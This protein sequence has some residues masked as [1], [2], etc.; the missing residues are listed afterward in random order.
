MGVCHSEPRDLQI[1]IG[2]AKKTKKL[3]CSQMSPKLQSIPLEALRLV[4]LREVWLQ[5]NEISE[6]S[7]KTEWNKVELVYLLGNRI[8]T[9][10]TAVSA[11][12]SLEELNLSD[13]PSISYLPE[14]C[15]SW[16]K[17]K[18]IYLNGLPALKRL[19]NSVSEWSEL[20]VFHCN[21]SGI[22]E[23][24]PGI[25]LWKKLLFFSC[26]DNVRLTQLPDVFH[27]LVHLEKMFLNSCRLAAFPDS[28]GGLSSLTKLYANQNKITSIP[29][30]FGLLS[31]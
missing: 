23:L 1:A 3:Q 28:F 7:T 30:C 4:D 19:P 18:Q 14:E 27:Q 8:S 31:R 17:L 13:N 24:P 11:W 20:K 29:P 2:N 12:I 21:N 15:G 10:P 22:E 25:G 9:V 5:D 6:I 26:N 16:K